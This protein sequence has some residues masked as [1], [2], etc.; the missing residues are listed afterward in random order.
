ML[1]LLLLALIVGLIAVV[2]YLALRSSAPPLPLSSANLDGVM[3]IAQI[4]AINQ[5]LA[6]QQEMA[7]SLRHRHLVLG[8][9]TGWTV[10]RRRRSPWHVSAP[11]LPRTDPSM[12][13]AFLEDDSEEWGSWSD[14]G[15]GGG[16]LWDVN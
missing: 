12:M 2:A 7:D 1:V 15:G 8:P 6:L 4:T 10:P 9:S 5:L 14:E 16:D 11:F 3:G 13:G